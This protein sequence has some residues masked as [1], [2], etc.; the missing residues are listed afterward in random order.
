[1][2]AEYNIKKMTELL[3]EE[4][5]ARNIQEA[6]S[7]ENAYTLFTENGVDASYEDFMNYIE[8]CRKHLAEQGHISEDGELSME[9]LELISGGKWYHAVPFFAAGVACLVTGQFVAGAVLVGVGAC[10]WYL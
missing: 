2:I 9:M 6:G 5:F 7:Y 3:A 1:M 4:E 10:V 8:E